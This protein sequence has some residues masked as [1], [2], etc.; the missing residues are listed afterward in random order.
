M[1]VEY[2]AIAMYGKYFRDRKE[3]EKFI[4][5][6][7]PDA[8]IDYDGVHGVPE[9]FEMIIENLNA[10][11]GDEWIVGFHVGIG[12]TLDEPIEL[13][14]KAFPGENATTHLEVKVY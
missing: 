1:G 14:E 6:H 13:W 5:R 10:Y 4:L 11:A 8:E 9:L 2:S 7:W 12:E 3:V